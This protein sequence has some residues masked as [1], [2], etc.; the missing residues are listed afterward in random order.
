MDRCYLFLYNQ[1]IQERHRHVVDKGKQRSSRLSAQWEP[2]DSLNAK[3]SNYVITTK[4]TQTH[5]HTHRACEHSWKFT[6]GK[7]TQ[8]KKKKKKKGTLSH[9]GSRRYFISALHT[10]SLCCLFMFFHHLSGTF[11]FQTTKKESDST[12]SFKSVGQW[13]NLEC[14]VKL[15]VKHFLK[16]T[17][18][19]SFLP[20]S[21]LPR[22][23]LSLSLAD[24]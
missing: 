12:S 7:V 8:A 11:F 14:Y 4:G 2:A 22:H 1:L 3:E 10:G 17:A 16:S 6:W 19:L 21:P 23:L 24:G 9:R 5:K 13:N 20:C 18:I 15:V